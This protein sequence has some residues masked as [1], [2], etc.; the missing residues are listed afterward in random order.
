MKINLVTVDEAHCI[1]QWGYDFRPS[2]LNIAQIKK[3]LPQVKFLALTATSKPKVV[4]DIQEKLEFKQ[5][6]V[7]KMSFQREN[8]SYLIRNVENKN[9]YLLDTLQKVSGSGIIYV[10]SR[11]GTREISDELR[12]NKISADFYHAGLSNLVRNSKQDLWVN[13][14]TRVIVATNAFGMG[15]D[16]A[17]VRFVIHMEPPDSLEAYFKEAGRAGRDGKKSAAVLLFNNSDKTK[18]KK[19]I[20]VAFPEIE[21]IKKI[22]ESL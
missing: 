2:Y 6:N 19:H 21:N 11:K 9:G 5:K 18:L 8:L 7:L 14:K 15:I 20:S 13:G 12:A 17:N 3:V 1:S 4:D 22:Y 10:R 16:K